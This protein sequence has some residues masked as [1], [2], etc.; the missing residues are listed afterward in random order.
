MFIKAFTSADVQKILDF[1]RKA[2]VFYSGTSNQILFIDTPIT[3][4]TVEAVEKLKAEG[5]RVVFRDH[6]GIDGEAANDR[7]RQVVAAAAKLEQLLSKDCLITVRRLHPACSTLVSVGEFKDALAIIADPDADGL[8]A[9]MKA[10]GIFYEGLDEDAAK[11]DGEPQLQVTGTAISQFLAKGIAAIPSYD[12]S[13]P[14][15]R[16]QEYQKLFTDWLKAV[17]GDQAAIKRLEER[18]LVYDDAVKVS[19]DLSRTA[20]TIAPGVVLVDVANKPLFDPGTLHALLEN[21][22]ECRVTVLRKSLGPLAAL[23]GIQYSL[24]V[25]KAYQNKLNLHNLLSSDTKSDREAGVISNVSFLLHVSEDVFQRQ[26]LPRLKK[27][28]WYD[29]G[30]FEK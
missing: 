30:K 16:E 14:R 4:G 24:S 2:A 7:E 12:A 23:H 13:K 15:E 18:V 11:L 19:L 1:V 22:P 6:H 21:D 3:S 27:G 8:T 20:R 17:S 26:V 9:A 5:Y 10:A 29:T 28:D 25:A